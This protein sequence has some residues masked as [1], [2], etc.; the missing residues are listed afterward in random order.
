LSSLLLARSA[1]LPLFDLN[2]IESAQLSVEDAY[3]SSTG[4]SLNYSEIAVKA[5]KKV[6][7]PLAIVCV[8]MN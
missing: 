2:I 6:H 8:S 7:L 3:L 5:M 4:I 1:H